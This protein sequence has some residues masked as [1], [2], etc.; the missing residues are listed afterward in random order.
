MGSCVDNTR[1]LRLV[2]E[3]AKYLGVDTPVL[4]VVGAAPEWMSEKAV[5]IG[6]YF[7]SSGVD[8]FLGTVPPVTGSA[9]FTD[10]LT[11]GL[12]DV[13]GAKFTVNEDPVQLAQAMLDRIEEKRTRLGI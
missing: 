6:T 12:E 3:V 1:I 13:Y 7:V 2:T 5:S 11:N 8:V 9:R 10:Y 4:P